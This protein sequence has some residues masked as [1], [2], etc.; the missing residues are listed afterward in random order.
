MSILFWPLCGPISRAWFRRCWSVMRRRSGRW[1]RSINWARR[2]CAFTRPMNRRRPWRWPPGWYWREKWTTWWREDWRRAPWWR[3]SSPGK[4]ECVP[5]GSCL[6][7]PLWKTPSTTSCSPS[8]I[9]LLTQSPIWPRKSRFW[10]M[11]WRYSTAWG[12]SAPRWPCWRRR[13]PLIPNFRRAQTPRH[14]R[15][16]ISGERL[17]AVSWRAQFPLTCPLSLSR[18]KSRATTARWRG[19]PTCLS[20]PIWCRATWWARWCFSWARAAPMW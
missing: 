9:P 20:A 11:P 19:M 14:W 7:W 4:M 5:G 10:R 18:P 3:R 8:P 2:V 15:R 1:W 6:R 16:C 12:W 17:P 13:R